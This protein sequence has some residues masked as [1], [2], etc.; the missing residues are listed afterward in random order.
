[1]FVKIA[2]TCLLVEN[3]EEVNKVEAELDNI[4]KHTSELEVKTFGG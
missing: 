3:Y 2:V 4:N 1:M